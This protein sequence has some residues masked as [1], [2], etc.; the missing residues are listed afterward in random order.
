MD[1]VDFDQTVPLPGL[2]LEA[3]AG[4]LVGVTASDDVPEQQGTWTRLESDDVDEM[5]TDIQPS[6]VLTNRVLR[7]GLT[8]LGKHPITQKHAFLSLSVVGKGVQNIDVIRNFPLL[9]F[10]DVSNNSLETLDALDS[11]PALVQLRAR[12]NR[13]TSCLDFAPAKC[14]KGNAWPTGQQSAGSMLTLADLGDNQI[15]SI[16]DLAKHQ[17][18]E[19]LLLSKN[20]ISVISGLSSLRFLKVR[21]GETATAPSLTDVGDTIDTECVTLISRA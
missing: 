7:T 18:L 11:L 12:G 2:L 4:A 19:C 20:S 9:M 21:D 16:Q 17:F 6:T 5:A 8:Q 14:D 10:V 1:A 15:E 3:D 13:L